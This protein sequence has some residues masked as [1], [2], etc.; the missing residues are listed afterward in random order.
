MLFKRDVVLAQEYL[1]FLLLN[2]FD[3]FLTGYI[4]RN[5]GLE[6]NGIAAWI[7]NHFHGQG[8]VV[9]KFALM[10][11][12]VACCEVISLKNIRTSRVIITGACL[13]YVFL[14]IYECFLIFSHISGP[15]SGL[16]PSSSS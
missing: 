7:L 4:L 5:Q 3:L 14:V 11:L 16:L 1:A 12:I 15:A 13:L 6:A 9:Y 10:I 8:F 2:L